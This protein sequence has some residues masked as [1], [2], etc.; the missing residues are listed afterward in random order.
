MVE[1]NTCCLDAHYYKHMPRSVSGDLQS[2][3]GWRRWCASLAR[4]QWLSQAK[5]VNTTN[6]SLGQ[7]R[8]ERNYSERMQGNT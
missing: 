1:V 8:N 5:K 2:V 3:S 7:R 4:H 6:H